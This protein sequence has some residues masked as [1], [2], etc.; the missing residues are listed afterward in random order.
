MKTKYLGVYAVAAAVF[1][2]AS[3]ADV[4]T[5]AAPA[6]ATNSIFSDAATDAVVCNTAAFVCY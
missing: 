4:A 1:D 6:A 3:V 2:T 5:D